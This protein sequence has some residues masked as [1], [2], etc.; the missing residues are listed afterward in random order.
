[1]SHEPTLLPHGSVLLHIGPY[2]TGSTAAQTALNQAR[3]RLAEHGVVYA[4]RG[5]RDRRAGWAV[6]GATPRGRQKAR[7]EEWQA[8][9]DE[10]RDAADRRVCVSNEDFARLG[11]VVVDRI[12][13]DL[14]RD[15]LHV[16]AVARRLDRLLPSQWQERVKS[17][18]TVT[19]DR[20]LREVLDPDS[21]HL[22]HRA[23]WASHGVEGMVERWGAA[24]GMENVTV[25]VGEDSD[26]TR[27]VRTFE[28]MLGLPDGLLELN[29]HSNP[30]LP[31]NGVELVRRLN[32]RFAA[33][34]SL[35]DWAYFRLVQRGAIPRMA[36]APRSPLDERIPPLPRWARDRVA[37]LS[38]DRVQALATLGVHVVGDPAALLVDTSEPAPE[39]LPAPPETIALDLA[40]RALEGAVQAGL[41]ERNKA[42][43]QARTAARPGRARK[44]APAPGPSVADTPAKELLREVGRRAKRRAGGRLRRGR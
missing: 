34:E 22:V 11:P 39:E 3:P 27:L 4:G 42:Q 32:E 8:L 17:H 10:V 28:A 29:E 1:M 37:E 26:R 40:L 13:E 14:G 20:Y 15:R 38:H 18:E 9:V 44:A 7:I 12:V 43:R 5:A 33:E 21:D 16:V 24:V 6:I 36:Y 41:D 31:M 30:S 23:F 2:K 19:Y 25:V 35:N